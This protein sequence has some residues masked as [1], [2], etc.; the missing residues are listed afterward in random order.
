MRVQIGVSLR[1]LVAL[2]GM[3]QCGYG[4][5][6]RRSWL[7]CVQGLYLP[8][9]NDMNQATFRGLGRHSLVVDLVLDQNARADLAPRWK[10]PEKGTIP[11]SLML[12]FLAK[13][14]Y[15]KECA[16]KRFQVSISMVL[17]D[18]NAGRQDTRILD[19]DSIELVYH[20]N[21]SR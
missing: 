10:A 14:A 19:D 6:E 3:A 7:S 8:V 21:G 1:V 11:S 5:D 20:D 17:V 16:G 18:R 2:V 12:M 9:V 15:R 4:A 13:Q